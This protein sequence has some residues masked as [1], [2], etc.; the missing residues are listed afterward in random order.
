MRLPPSLTALTLLSARQP[1]HTTL[2]LATL[3]S[4]QEIAL[5]DSR[6]RPVWLMQLGS[7]PAMKHI[8]LR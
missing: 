8:H 7:L 6:E 1:G 3:Q 4:L 2:N 5:L